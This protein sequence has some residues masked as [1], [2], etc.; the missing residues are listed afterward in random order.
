ME[1]GDTAMVEAE[2][3]ENYFSEDFAEDFDRYELMCSKFFRNYF[4]VFTQF[5]RIITV[6]FI[7]LLAGGIM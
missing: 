4:E 7:D 2:T 3:S 6:Y 5:L 1:V